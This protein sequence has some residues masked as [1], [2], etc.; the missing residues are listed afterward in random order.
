M[1]GDIIRFLKS[2]RLF[3]TSD[4]QENVFQALASQFQDVTLAEDEILFHEGEPSK[5]LCILVQGKLSAYISTS[6]AKIKIIGHILPGETIGE[7]GALSNDPR[8]LTVKAIEPSR[9]LKLPTITFKKFCRQYPGIL[10]NAVEPL[11]SR[12]QNIIRL[13]SSG[14]SRKHIAIIP[15]HPDIDVQAFAEQIK[16]NLLHYKKVSLLIDSAYNTLGSPDDNYETL[17]QIAEDNNHLILYLLTSEETSLSKLCWGKIG[18]IYVLGDGNE[19]PRYSQ[20]VLRKLNDTHNLVEVR[21]ELILIHKKNTLPLNTELWLHNKNYFMHHNIYADSLHD[22]QRLLRFMRGKALGLVLGGGGV[23][24][25]AH[26]GV[27]KALLDAN[28]HIDAIGGTSVGAMVAGLYAMN[29][30]YNVLYKKFTKLIAATRNTVSLKKLCWPAVSLFNCEDFTLE[31]ENIFNIKK[32]E[33]LLIPFFCVSTN[34][35]QYKETTHRSG[36]LWEKVRGS[37]SIPGIVPPMIIHGELHVD[38]G[39][40]NN[41]PVNTMRELLGPESRII[42]VELMSTNVDNKSYCFPPTLTFKQ[43]FLAKVGWGYQTYQFPQFIDTFL[44]SLLIGASLKQA[45]NALLADLL[46]TLPTHDYSMLNLQKDAQNKL[47]TLG[48]NA[49]RDDIQRWD[50]K[51]K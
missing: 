13:L 38:G 41:L 19:K 44:K 42:A 9:V 47:W 37:T 21:R 17:M 28:I 27:L 49:A 8:T 45:E 25:W 51:K 22:Y 33:D 18:K 6:H 11:A 46:I 48:Y 26:I 1:D 50:T 30:D 2:S 4:L 23:K 10:I 32:I 39:L 3:A 35:G 31:L 16:K 29:A 40:V 24:G 15:A 36:F 7:L 12:S 34:L 14:E 20:H 43:A 5:Y